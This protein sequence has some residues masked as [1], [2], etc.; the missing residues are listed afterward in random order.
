MADPLV[1]AVVF[2]ALADYFGDERARARPSASLV[3]DLKMD[4]DDVAE[5]IIGLEEA[6]DVDLPNEAWEPVDTPRDVVAVLEAR[7]GPPAPGVMRRPR[8]FPEARFPFASRRLGVDGAV[9][10]YVDEG[11]GPPLLF[12]HGNP[13][14]SFLYR[15]VIRGLAGRFRCIAL[16]YPGFGLSHAPAGYDFRPAS[17]AQIVERFIEA[18]DLRGMALVAQDWGGPIGLAVA[19]R[20]PDRFRALVIGNSWAWP[21]NGDPHFERFAWLFGGPAGRF[22]IRHFNAF[23]NLLVPAGVKRRRLPPDVMAAYR[24]PL[25]LAPRR[26]ATAV[27]P[28]EIVK[29]RDFLAA[30]EA[31]LPRLAHLPLLLLWGDRDVAFRESERLRFEAAFPRHRTVVLRGAGHY[32]Q[33]D[34][35]EVMARAM[36]RWWE[37]EVQGAG[38]RPPSPRATLP[39]RTASS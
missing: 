28:R 13:T 36:L 10:H 23:V 24:S 18:L 37:E 30:V 15:D 12:L 14:W 20:H 19:G 6:L 5:F 17:H 38:P 4:G 8:W 26:M 3:R 9:V 2:E 27:F 7:V 35:P 34:A 25:A 32:I 29:S 16:D 39:G 11:D 31:G 33:E 21:V 22:A 1:D